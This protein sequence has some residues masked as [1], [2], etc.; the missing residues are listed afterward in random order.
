MFLPNKRI[1]IESRRNID[2][3]FC[4]SFENGYEIMSYDSTHNTKCTTT[5]EKQ[6]VGSNST[7]IVVFG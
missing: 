6:I 5:I 1:E 4:N 2:W 3:K 7:P